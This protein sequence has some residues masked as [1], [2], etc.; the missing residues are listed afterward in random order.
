MRYSTSN[1]PDG[2]TDRDIDNLFSDDEHHLACKSTQ[3]C[4][5]QDCD[6]DSDGMFVYWSEVHRKY[7]EC[8]DHSCNCDIIYDDLAYDAAEAKFDMMR[9]RM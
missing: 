2:V 5:D 7:I 3:P 8:E 6:R 9:E 4:V 1:Y